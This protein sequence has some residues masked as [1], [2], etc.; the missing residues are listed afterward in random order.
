MKLSHFL[1][2][3]VLF[4][5][6]KQADRS[7]TK[8]TAKNIAID[9]T[10]IPSKEIEDIITPYR[11]K[12]KGDMQEALTYTSI[13]LTKK[14]TNQQSSLGNLLADMC[15]EIANPVFIEKTSTSIDFS[16]F[17]YGGIRAT[18]PTGKVTKEHAFKLMPFENEFVVVNLK[19]DKIIALINY[20]IQNKTAHPLSKNI[21]LSIDGN[22]YILKINGKIFDKSK[23]YSVLTTDYL[24]GGG[25]KMNFFKD[26]AKLTKLDY[27]MRDAIINYFKKVDTLK[28]TIDNRVNIK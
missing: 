14:S 6:C 13:N 16:M 22:D 10:I 3:L 18:I 9:S 20:F 26:P 25:D 11:A 19:G 23:T 8:I 24:Q 4:S 27:K 12:L 1:C 2:F 5:S 28:T 17:N 15:Y 21:E 7:L